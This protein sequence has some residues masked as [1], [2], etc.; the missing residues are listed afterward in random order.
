MALEYRLTIAR[1]TTITDLAVRAF[2]D[3]AERPQGSPS[4]LVADLYDRY[5]F[6]VTIYAGQNG[7]RSAE[8]DDGMWE[9]KPAEYI[10]MSFRMDKTAHPSQTLPAMLAAVKRV[11]D[12]GAEDVAL[13]LNGN[14]LLLTRVNGVITKHKR[15]GWWEVHGVVD[16]IIPA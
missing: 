4:L 12:S 3:P 16:P 1:A 5:G 8:S 14:W 7:Y 6:E 9:W 13:D 11:L 10:S 15:D 2:P